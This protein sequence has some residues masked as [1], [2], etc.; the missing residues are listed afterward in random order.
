MLSRRQRNLRRATMRHTRVPPSPPC[1]SPG[2]ATNNAQIRLLQRLQPRLRRRTR[3]LSHRLLCVR[4]Q[5]LFRHLLQRRE[6]VLSRGERRKR[7]VLSA[8]A[9]VLREHVLLGG[10]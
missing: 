6:P 8:G 10:D 9:D 4:D 7:R 5:V 1:Y 3:L 2:L